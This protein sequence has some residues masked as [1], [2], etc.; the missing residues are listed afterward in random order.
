[1]EPENNGF[2]FQKDFPFQ[3]DLF[4]GSFGVSNTWMWDVLPFLQIVNQALS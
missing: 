3:P 1:M 2:C 4:S